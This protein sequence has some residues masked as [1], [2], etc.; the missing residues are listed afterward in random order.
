MDNNI[1]GLAIWTGPCL[2]IILKLMKQI[3]MCVGA[4][5]MLSGGPWKL[6]EDMQK[7]KE[8]MEKLKG[9]AQANKDHMLQYKE[10][11]QVNEVALKQI[12]SAHEKFKVEADKLKK[13]LEDEI[14]FLNGRVSELESDL[15]SK[16]TEV[17]STVS[18][19]EEALSSAFTE[20]DCLKEENFVEMSQ[21][22][23]LEIQISSLKEDLEKEHQH[24]HTSQSNYE[25][26]VYS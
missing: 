5:R 26:Q 13:S 16:S 10:I 12:E 4:I 25:R 17:T 24:W 6:I 21:I 1:G 19:K 11:A 7:A 22:V 15:V 20:I 2:C 23:E 8:E 3:R 18:G 9:E 14:H